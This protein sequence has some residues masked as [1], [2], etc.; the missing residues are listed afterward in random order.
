MDFV[1]LTVSPSP[2]TRGFH[3]SEKLPCLSC[4]PWQK[5][6]IA[7]EFYVC[8]VLLLSLDSSSRR[9]IVCRSQGLTKKHGAN[10]SSCR[11]SNQVV[12]QLFLHPGTVIWTRV[13]LYI[14]IDNNCYRLVGNTMSLN[15]T[16]HLANMGL[17]PWIYEIFRSNSFH[18][19]SQC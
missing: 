14:I 18:W 8:C 17:S 2:S 7:G 9:S 4:L 3:S 10:V 6:D 5:S 1:F 16:H 19:L 13:F 15:N 11:N 12:K